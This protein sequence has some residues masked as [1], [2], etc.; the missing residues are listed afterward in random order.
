MGDIQEYD[1]KKGVDFTGVSIS[2][3]VM[4]AKAMCS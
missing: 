1:K 3:F 4:T 2:F